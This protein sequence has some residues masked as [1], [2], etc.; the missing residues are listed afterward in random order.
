MEPKKWQA[1]SGGNEVAVAM[2]MPMVPLVGVIGRGSLC[3]P[4]SVSVISRMEGKHG[5]PKDTVFLVL[6]DPTP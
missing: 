6:S 4:D 5:L 3:S 2:Q 1:S